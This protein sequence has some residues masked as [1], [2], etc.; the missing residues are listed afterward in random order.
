ME[1]S[2]VSSSESGSSMT[3]ASILC[4]LT[5]MLLLHF[6]HNQSNRL[7]FIMYKK[8]RVTTS[9]HARTRVVSPRTAKEQGIF[10]KLRHFLV[11]VLKWP[12]PPS[13]CYIFFV[14]NH[15]LSSKIPSPLKLPFWILSVECNPHHPQDH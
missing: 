7:P 9:L 4:G 11:R 3:R 10:L 6:A 2:R 8:T 14:C 12:D 15:G 5:R 13:S 1:S